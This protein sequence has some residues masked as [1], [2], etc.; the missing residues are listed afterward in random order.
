MSE[1]G[2]VFQK[3]GGGTNF[4][5]SIQT[6]F[7]VTML[8]GGNV[9]CL[10]SSRISE[11]AL[12]VTNRGYETDDLLV[13]TKSEDEEH[14]IL[15]QIK[16][17][18]LFTVNSKI[19]KEVFTDF[20]KD[21]NKTELFDKSK[22]K[23]II[24]K[25]GLTKNEKNHLKALFNWANTHS[26]AS[27]FISEV[28]R[29]KAKREQLDVFR[30]I[31]KEANNNVE[32][33][34]ETLWEFLKCVD[35]LEYDFLNEGSIC[36]T[37]FLNLI[38]L[39]K[40]E[41]SI[42]S[43]EDIWNSIYSYVSEA[44]P[45]GGS[46]TCD[47]IKSE[48]FYKN[49]D[50]KS[51]IPYNKAIKKLLNDSVSI[52]QPVKSTIG[53]ENNIIHFQRTE[54]IDEILNSI[55]SSQITIITG[56]PGT[57]KTAA[58]KDLLNKNYSNANVLVFRADQ[59]NEPTLANV[60]TQLG[61]NESISDIFSSI[62]LISDKIIF[63]DSLEKLLE[64]DPDCAFSQ[65]MTMIKTFPD[66]KVVL[67]SRKYALDLISIKFN[68]S[69][70]NSQIIEIPL[71]DDDNLNEVSDKYTNIESLIKND[72]IRELLRCP[73]YLD[74]ALRAAYKSKNNLSDISIAGFK[75][76]LWNTL[77]VNSQNTRNGM[78]IKR[79]KAFMDIALKRAKEMKL[80]TK[81][82]SSVDADALVCLE[83]DE[84]IFQEN[85][86]R[87]YS[88]THDILEDWALVRYVAEKFDEYLGPE[89]FINLGNEPSI[90]RAF[91]LWTEDYLNNQNHKIVEL[92]KISLE[93][94]SIEKYWTDEILTAIFRS[95]NS[96]CFFK[97]LEKELLLNDAELFDKSMH[98]IKTCC[99]EI[100][101]SNN[102]N[103]NLVPIGDGW[104]CAL[105]FINKHI[106]QLNN[107]R[108][109]ILTFMSDWYKKLL[110]KYNDVNEEEK[111]NAK[112]I[113][114]Y[115]IKEFEFGIHALEDIKLDFLVS[116]LFDLSSVSKEDIESLIDRCCD[117][118]EKLWTLKAL[119]KVVKK[120]ILSGIGNFHFLRDFPEIVV[121]FAWK[122]WRYYLREDGN[123]DIIPH[124]LYENECWGIK[125]GNFFPSGI[126]KTPF[127]NLLKIHPIE[128]IKFIVEFVN[129]AVDF[130]TN[131]Y[132]N[133]YYKHNITKI[134]I[135]IY[136][137]RISSIYASEELWLAFR[138][139][140][141]TSYLLE[142][143]LM[144]LEK[145]LLEM[146]ANNSDTSY[147]ILD[148]MFE[149]IL[150]NSNNVAPI[151]VL[152][153]IIMA[154]PI[155]VGKK[156]L[157]IFSVKEFYTWD[158][159]RALKDH[160]P[161]A[162]I[163]FEIVIAQE[164]RHNSNQLLHR[165]KYSRGLL[166][167][168]LDYQFNIRILNDDL[169][170][171]F[172]V[173]KEKS[174]NSEDIV[175]K[176]NLIEIDIRNQKIG[177]YDPKLGGF[178]IYTIY[179]EEIDDYFEDNKEEEFRYQES[180]KYAALLTKA[181]KNKD[182][183]NYEEWKECYIYY[184]RINES[185]VLHTMKILDR[186]ITLAYIGL[187]SFSNLLSSEQKNWCV[188]KLNESIIDIIDDTYHH[189]FG[190]SVKYNLLEKDVAL[191]S[192]H[193]L[194]SNTNNGDEKDIIIRR[195]IFM[196]TAPFSNFDID[197]I[198][199]YIREVFYKY[200]PILTKR[201]WLIL[202]ELSIYRKNIGS[203][204][205]CKRESQFKDEIDFIDSKLSENNINTDLSK[206]SFAKCDKF[207][208]SRLIPL[209]PIHFED[210]DFYDFIVHILSLLLDDM[211]KEEKMR[212]LSYDDYE[213][214]LY[215]KRYL[216]LCLLDSDTNFSIPLFKLLIESVLE[217]EPII[218]HDRDDLLE[219][220]NGTLDFYVLKLHD[221]GILKVP[222][223]TYKNKVDNFWFL[224]EV[225][226]NLIPDN[227]DNPIIKK[228]LL[229]VK[230]LLYDDKHIPNEENWSIL[231]SKGM[232]YR[233]ILMNKG[234]PHISSAIK[235]LST[236]GDKA[237]MPDGVHWIVDILKSNIEQQ[238]CLES[239]DA[240]RMIHNL[241]KNH[242]YIIKS[243]KK[244][245]DDYLWILNKMVELGSS[246]AYF[247]RENVITY[248]N[249]K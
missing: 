76:L 58:I 161:L 128:G 12:Q 171:I 102:N 41:S 85:N 97:A 82:D 202:I 57:G 112:S 238:S 230:F 92:I 3:G 115:Y 49:F 169:F 210:S 54:L 116:I 134:D 106:E 98:I 239:P 241:Y 160:S 218:V 94:D 163:D 225:F 14:R 124:R 95:D 229:D 130:Y 83:N 120:R 235:V 55:N 174:D 6:A 184:T 142:S 25:S 136:D 133:N 39:C 145:Y 87:K 84:I 139:H 72:K 182:I 40:S 188:E 198:I 114:L 153:S 22:D 101:V 245:I 173:L 166:D 240:E 191:S 237:F 150:E 155:K 170:K 56:K 66:I 197:I 183:I 167:F 110:F 96:D 141:V 199:K 168:V 91:R 16:H 220:I 1:K 228:L 34:D 227:S 192:F 224:W 19:C 156:M 121:K 5:Q 68:I 89:F 24:V 195:M 201:I 216:A 140:S 23:L 148:Y 44:N 59:F 2:T 113:V 189:G 157:P 65:F 93:S 187:D 164:E 209:T 100:L 159:T 126:Y 144:S 249:N 7:L 138:G 88:P 152:S 79:E 13:I 78:P 233:E 15:I 232:F 143:L 206:I 17:D 185:D 221:N 4:E 53:I 122:E 50:V 64:S 219:F 200:Y 234:K 48:D 51:I 162:P 211:K 196:L 178:P 244:L 105:S 62:S 205:H 208:L 77:V 28:N 74:F 154:Y 217:H 18:I 103:T 190:M 117:N 118:K 177:E 99:K 247:I 243:D 71:L 176:K 123:D 26:S 236:I 215:I 86:N 31:L 131:T 90:R 223:E 81:P 248:K 27:D 194:I 70:Y 226:Y 69:F 180:S 214:I 193:L 109:S 246:K 45:N 119:Y 75:D 207:I 129:Y 104:S 165:R 52:L 46:F 38:K 213:M 203:D 222:E 179:D 151:A 135:V 20:W 36:K 37:Y 212:I 125:N 42:I 60:F 172:D 147:T 137:N 111:K 80:F 61:I 107:K 33:T 32:L 127:Y 10:P 30:T 35:V 9:P 73:K 204:L 149:Y 146:A 132:G 186:P 231:D 43:E 21:F 108:L 63:I 158:L 47:S 8:V 242:I 29:I 67:A 175:W 11:I 181:W